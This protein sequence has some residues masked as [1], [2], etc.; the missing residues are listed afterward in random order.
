MSG[1]YT[2]TLQNCAFFARHGVHDEEEFLGQRFFVDAEL[3]VAA[4]EALVT[5]SID[6]TV[7]YGVAFT[8]IEEIVTGKRRYLIEAL[9]LDVAKGLCEKFPQIKRV[10]VT[11]RK[12][13]APVPGV[14]DY[15]Q[16]SIEHFA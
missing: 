13:N 8:V 11:V 10:R 1:I 3:D 16:V 12:P 5:D 9:A 6:G 7:N 15:V 2:I 14:L 4:G